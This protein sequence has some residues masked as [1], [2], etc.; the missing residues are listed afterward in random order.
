MRE[1]WGNHQVQQPLD[2]AVRRKHSEPRGRIQPDSSHPTF[3]RHSTDSNSKVYLDAVF[4]P[5]NGPKISANMF[6]F[7]DP[8]DGAIQVSHTLPEAF[9]QMLATYQPRAP[10]EA[11]LKDIENRHAGICSA[12]KRGASSKRGPF[13]QRDLSTRGGVS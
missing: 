8:V 1:G 13:P 10:Q 11:H 9:D 3:H 4:R 5:G 6:N 2:P 12:S 7:T